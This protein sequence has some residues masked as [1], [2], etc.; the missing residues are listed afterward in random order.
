MRKICSFGDFDVYVSYSDFFEEN[1][2]FLKK[3]PSLCQISIEYPEMEILYDEIIISKSR[4]PEELE[5]EFENLIE[6]LAKPESIKKIGPGPL[7][8]VMFTIKD[9]YQA[10][11]DR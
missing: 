10:S 5:N 1:Q 7:D 6:K 3:G 8:W 2:L 9:K 11:P 4:I